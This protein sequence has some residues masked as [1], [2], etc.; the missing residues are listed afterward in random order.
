MGQY[1]NA[2]THAPEP[3]RSQLAVADEEA[4]SLTGQTRDN[5]MT[6][7]IV[8]PLDGKTLRETGSFEGYTIKLY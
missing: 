1:V 6:Q 5:E 3:S 4:D 7:K 8:S 2:P